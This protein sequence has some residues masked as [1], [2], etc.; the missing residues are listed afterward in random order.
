MSE[1][2]VR[3]GFDTRNVITKTPYLDL[4]YLAEKE[5]WPLCAEGMGVDGDELLQQF[6]DEGAVMFAPGEG[7]W[8]TINK[9]TIEAAIESHYRNG[10]Y[11]G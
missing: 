2:T 8:L 7:F 3:P 1:T 5:I 9:A 10:G 4:A 6:I 11:G